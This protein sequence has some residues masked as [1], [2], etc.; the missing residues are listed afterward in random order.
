MPPTHSWLLPLHS[1]GEGGVHVLRSV[2]PAGRPKRARGLQ[3][4]WLALA[5]AKQVPCFPRALRDTGRAASCSCW[6]V[7]SGQRLPG[8][9]KRELSGYA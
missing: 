3:R 5:Q 1:H 8:A 4:R 7:S 2:A 6:K 9:I